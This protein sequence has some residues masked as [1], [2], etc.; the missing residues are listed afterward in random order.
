MA[1]PG[2]IMSPWG[3]A[4]RRRL[5]AEQPGRPIRRVRRR[6]VARRNYDV[7]RAPRIY[8]FADQPPR[9]I[10]KLVYVSHHTSAGVGA[11]AINVVEYRANGMYDPEVAVGGHQPYG[12]DQLM[13]QYYHY[14][15]IGAKFE[16]ECQTHTDSPQIWMGMVYNNTGTAASAYASGGV[17]GLCEMPVVSRSLHLVSQDPVMAQQRSQRLYASMSKI[18]GKTVSNLIGDARFQGDDSKDPDEQAYFALVGYVP[19]GTQSDIGAFFKI[20][21]VYTAVFTEPRFF[22]TS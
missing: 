1:M 6:I 18:F 11:G 16:I 7:P 4:R 15:V 13:A 8:H 9:K 22:T 5:D 21:I 14:T 20:K 2:G 17:N 19:N 3:L 10:A 12:F